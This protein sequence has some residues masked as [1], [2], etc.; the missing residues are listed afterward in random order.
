MTGIGLSLLISLLSLEAHCVTLK[1]SSFGS[2][3]PGT[4]RTAEGWLMVRSDS[5]VTWCECAKMR[6]SQ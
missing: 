5:T 3:K 2:M 6:R 4:Y 1:A